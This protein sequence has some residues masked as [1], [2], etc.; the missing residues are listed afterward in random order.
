[1]NVS[2]QNRCDAADT[3]WPLP[4]VIIVFADRLMAVNKENVF[5]TLFLCSVEILYQCILVLR[6]MPAQHGFVFI[7]FP[8]RLTLN[9]FFFPQK[10]CYR[11][12]TTRTYNATEDE[13]KAKHY[14]VHTIDSEHQGAGFTKELR[15]HR[16]QADHVNMSHRGQTYQT[17]SNRNVNK[18]QEQNKK[19]EGRK[20]QHQQ[21]GRGRPAYR[22]AG[23][24]TGPTLRKHG[25]GRK[26]ENSKQVSLRYDT[27]LHLSGQMSSTISEWSVAVWMKEICRCRRSCIQ[28]NHVAY[29]MK[30]GPE[31]KWRCQVLTFVSL[32][33]L[34][35]RV[36][37]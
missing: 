15:H 22:G 20:T 26:R 4:L 21:R 23:H 11:A 1:M 3:H 33:Q 14:R 17:R 12:Q 30:T 24:H 16:N 9:T 25:E 8:R 28:I 6:C 34:Y 5:G 27:W 29:I 18:Q 19:T 35:E 2:A 36:L 31:M 10:R 32:S 13:S 37:L 7:D